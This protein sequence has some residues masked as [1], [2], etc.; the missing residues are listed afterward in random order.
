MKKFILYGIGILFLLSLIGSAFGGNDKQKADAA[1]AATATATPEATPTVMPQVTFNMPQRIVVAKPRVTIKGTV[2]PATA[3]VNVSGHHPK[4]HA[5]GSFSTSIPVKL[6]HR[7]FFVDGNAVGYKDSDFGT[8]SV[9]RKRSH[10]ENVRHRAAVARKRAAAKAAAEARRAQYVANFKANAQSIPYKQLQK[11]ADAHSGEHVKFYGQ[12][13][14]IQED[15]FGDGGMMLLSVTDLGYDIYTD[16]VWVNYE[17]KV[18]GAED[19]MLTVYGTVVGSKSY[20]TQI[21]GETYVP[22]IDAKFIEE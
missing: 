22:E 21:G 3:K 13:M 12:I 6:G 1:P 20:D 18:N 9:T 5:D 8:V 7:K 17:G 15:T 19:D 14:Q 10:A 4:V 2:T 16:N 11:N